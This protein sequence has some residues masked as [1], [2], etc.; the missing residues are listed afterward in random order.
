MPDTEARQRILT[1]HIDK[2]PVKYCTG[3]SLSGCGRSDQDRERSGEATMC[4]CTNI[5]ASRDDLALK[6]SERLG[7]LS[8]A[9]LV[10]VCRLAAMC[11]MRRDAEARHVL[12]SDFDTACQ[13]VKR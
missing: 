2:L 1:N 4:E 12:P 13:E 9:E 6:I 8:G 10:H 11:A 7:G 3:P 5:G